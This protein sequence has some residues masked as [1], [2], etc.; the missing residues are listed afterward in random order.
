LALKPGQ[1]PSFKL[2]ASKT[3]CPRPICAELPIIPTI[4]VHTVVVLVF[5]YKEIGTK[6]S[7]TV[8]TTPDTQQPRKSDFLSPHLS[9]HLT[10]TL[11]P[12]P[13]RWYYAAALPPQSKKWFWGPLGPENPQISALEADFFQR[14]QETLQAGFTEIQPQAWPWP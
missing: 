3:T 13:P 1:T 14:W 9:P 4:T 7:L 10:I 8:S 5:T 11:S 2:C 6:M 12:S